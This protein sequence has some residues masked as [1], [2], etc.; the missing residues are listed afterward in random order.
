MIISDKCLHF[1]SIAVCQFYVLNTVDNL[2]NENEGKLW[3]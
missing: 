3:I 2:L 1:L